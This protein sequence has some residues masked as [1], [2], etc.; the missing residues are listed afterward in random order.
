MFPGESAPK[1]VGARRQRRLDAALVSGR[2]RRLEPSQVEVRA[3]AKRREQLDPIFAR[4]TARIRAAA[5]RPWSTPDYG[6]TAD[7]ALTAALRIQAEVKRESDMAKLDWAKTRTN[8]HGYEQ[9]E[10]RDRVS[11]APA[12]AAPSP[13]LGLYVDPRCEEVIELE[14]GRVVSAWRR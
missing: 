14:Y 1:H 2:V 13:W 9:S 5:N 6:N 3:V 8:T 4:V 7:D 11:H 12:K 10:P